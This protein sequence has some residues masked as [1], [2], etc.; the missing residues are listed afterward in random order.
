MHQNAIISRLGY[1]K[2]CRFVVMGWAFGRKALAMFA[3]ARKAG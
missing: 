3:N 1:R 2:A